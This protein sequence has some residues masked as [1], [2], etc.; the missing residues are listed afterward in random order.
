MPAPLTCTL[1][2]DFTPVEGETYGLGALIRELGELKR[3]KEQTGVCTLFKCTD[4]SCSDTKF[5]PTT[6]ASTIFSKISLTGSFPEGS[7]VFP[8]VIANHYHLLPTQYITVAGNTLTVN[9]PIPSPLL[10][11]N[12][13]GIL[14]KPETKYNLFT[15]GEEAVNETTCNL[16]E[17]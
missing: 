14:P 10:S 12:L 1:K 17:G 8:S 7:E 11:V 9:D 13:W 5:Q 15:G 6:E 16:F 2:Y 4:S 3:N